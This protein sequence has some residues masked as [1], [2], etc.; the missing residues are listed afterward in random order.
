MATHSGSPT[1]LLSVLLL[2]LGPASSVGAREWGARGRASRQS[3]SEQRI[4]LQVGGRMREYVVHVPPSSGGGAPVPV[5]LMLHGGGGTAAAELKGTGL[6]RKADAAGFLLVLPEGTR[7][8]ASKPARFVGNPQTWND[9]SARF[10][11]GEQQIDDVGFMN[12]VLDDLMARFRVDE[13]RIFVTGFS[14]GASMAYRVGMEL[15]PR[16]AA[17]APIAASGLRIPSRQLASPVSLVSIHGTADPR[18]PIEGGDVH[19]WGKSDPR[20]PTRETIRMWATMLHC[21][22]TPQVIREG[23][24]VQGIAYGPCDAGSEV[25]FYTVEELGHVWPGGITL[26]P[27]RLVGKPSDALQANDVIWD[28]FQRHPKPR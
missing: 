6:A 23:G 15:A 1:V 21:P 10:A 13:R 8:H 17:I 12:A 18:N 3:Q 19:A 16:I 24:G 25:A 7:P 27:Q 26:L 28:F 14:N 5:V 11:A 20:P 9:G 4:S 22:M 2:L